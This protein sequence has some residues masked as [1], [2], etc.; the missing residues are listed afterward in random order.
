[1]TTASVSERKVASSKSNNLFKWFLIIFLIW[2]LPSG[3]LWTGV[4]LF[5]LENSAQRD[6]IASSELE[7]TLKNIAYDS[8][9]VK[10]FQPKFSDLFNQL[11][12]LP[13]NPSNLQKILDSFSKRWQDGMLE[14]YLFDS[15]KNILKTRGAHKG[16]ELFYRLTEVDFNAPKP[17]QA[18]INEIG[19]FMPAPQLTINNLRGQKDRVI[20]LGSPDR[21]SLCYLDNIQQGNSTCVGGILIFV[22]YEKLDITKILSETITQEETENF[23]YISPK[24][25]QL[26]NV[27][28]KTEFDAE[29]IKECYQSYP[30]N[31]FS[32]N[33][34]IF[35]VNRLNENTLLVGAVPCAR[36]HKLFMVTAL[37]LF[38]LVSAIFFKVTYKA[39]VI[40]VAY[41]LNLRQ[42]IIWLFVLCYIF[43]L[44]SAG[45]LAS[46]YLNE[47]KHSLLAQ[48]KAENY[49][50]LS[51]IDS[52]FSRFI[53]SKLMDYRN[54]TKKLSSYSENPEIIKGL[55]SDLCLDNQV[56]SIHLISSD[57]TIL[58]SSDLVSSEVRRH[59]DKTNEEQHEILE[60]WKLRHVP[61]APDLI[62][63]LFDRK[64][65]NT[66][67]EPKDRTDSHKALLKVFS[68]TA[69]SAMEYYNMSNNIDSLIIRKAANL[70]VDA[71]IEANSNVLFQT[72]KTNISRFTSLEG[73]DYS[74]MAFLDIIHGP[75]SEAWYTY[76]ALI[77]LANLE[78]QYLTQLFNDLKQ[79]NSMINRVFAEEDIR[80]ISMLPYSTNFPS[81]MEFTKFEPIF[82]RSVNDSKAFTHQMSL[83]GENVYVSVLRG[84][85]LKGYLLLK[86]FKESKIENLFKKQTKTVVTIFIV[87][88]VIGLALARLMT[89]VLI[90]PITDI[91]NGIKAI[92][93]QKYDYRI[94]IRSDNEF[95]VMSK[96]FNETALSLG[97]L[98]ILDS[99]SD[100]LAP[101]KTF[102][103][104]SY[105]I[106][107][108][109]SATKTVLSDLFVYEPM[110]GSI[111]GFMLAEV[112]GN[113]AIAANIIAMLKAAF[114]GICPNY[115][116]NPEIVMSKLNDI[117]L[118]YKKPGHVIKCFIGLL[119]P[120][121][122]VM[123]FSNAGQTYPLAINER[124]NTHEIVELPSTPI[125]L[126]PN[127]KFNKKEISLYHKVL[128]LYS[129]GA[130]EMTNSAGEKLGQEAFINIAKD[131]LKA[132]AKN[133]ANEML[134]HL[135]NYSENVLWRDDITLITI[136]SI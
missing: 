83:D 119:D 127:T 86:V 54:L 16:L 9:I 115:Y 17:T 121:N 4:Y 6:N 130:I 126:S 85:Y 131:S 80:A 112:S 104:G 18:Q 49:R 75:T 78:R 51:E 28:S 11:K 84:S 106:H 24:K 41:N 42:R 73:T 136:A 117:F 59:S 37:L 67:P 105:I 40:G 3:I 113:D 31:S 114:I 2:G 81:I 57:S 98:R 55:L 30:T 132:D 1:M 60:S 91:I 15:E 96:A 70:V 68:S 77:D 61:L 14:I 38:L 124:Q 116:R 111:G 134:K 10:Y 120:T 39:F 65:A 74:I 34:F 63:Y 109:N 45:I 82:K 25:N 118:Q 92:A 122:D 12:G 125:G 50:R 43:P 95:G 99:M 20:E 69:P 44:L 128:V 100:Y 102:R 62:T 88:L 7:T 26:P 66:F 19:Q 110:K 56:D 133:S 53:T 101:E 23:G 129:D 87:I 72:A 21:Y 90:L 89:R 32:K 93:S 79:R 5:I 97:K 94:K 33:S 13:S 107:T 103:C 135:T 29:A 47:L 76:A 123:L 108:A 27:L 35:C 58:L 52:G 46:Q 8:S 22:H 71:V 48:E 36:T 64:N